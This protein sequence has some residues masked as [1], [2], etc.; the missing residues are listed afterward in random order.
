MVT[1]AHLAMH[2]A[3]ISDIAG[4]IHLARGASSCARGWVI[5][6]LRRDTRAA[7]VQVSL[8]TIDEGIF[9]VKAT[10]GDTHLGGED[11]DQMLA[12]H[13]VQ[14]CPPY[15]ISYMRS[16]QAR[17]CCAVLAHF[18]PDSSR[19]CAS[20]NRLR[21]SLHCPLGWERAASPTPMSSSVHVMLRH[22]VTQRDHQ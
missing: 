5:A 11:F 13:F 17:G 9:E 8:L 20:C 7:A 10:G 21:S 4:L 14:A 2:D 3:Q 19:A 16:M 18:E 22:P 1:V 6:L 12:A 15:A